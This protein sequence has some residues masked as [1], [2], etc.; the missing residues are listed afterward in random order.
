VN[1]CEYNN[2]VN[3]DT[4]L[5]R[6]S[7]VIW[8]F[9]IVLMCALVYGQVL[10]HDFIEYDDQIHFYNNPEFHP[11]TFA[12]LADFW[13]TQYEGL[14]IPVSYTF[15]A[16]IILVGRHLPNMTAIKQAADFNPLA[17]H[18]ASLII[19]TISSLIVFSLLRRWTCKDWP[20][21]VGALFFA[22]HPLQ[23]ESVCWASELRGLLA[24]AFGLG[25]V[26]VFCDR[27]KGG[28]KRDFWLRSAAAFAL[29][30]L[31]AL[32][33]P[34]MVP[35]PIVA[36]IFDRLINNTPWK[37]LAAEL[38][39]WLAVSAAV[40]I[41][42][43]SVQPVFE[44]NDTSLQDRPFIV[45]DTLFFYLEKL[46][47]PIKLSVDYGRNVFDVAHNPFTLIELCLLLALLGIGSWAGY[48]RRWPIACGIVSL[49]LILPVSGVVPY[50]FQ[51]F[52]TVGDRY[53]YAPILGAAMFI[54]RAL[55][56]K[57]LPQKIGVY[58]SGAIILMFAGLSA[59][60]AAL[61]LNARV[62]M[63]SATGLSSQC[64]QAYNVLGYLSQVDA[65]AA[66]ENEGKA[67]SL[68]QKSQ[69]DVIYKDNLLKS[70]DYENKSIALRPSFAMSHFALAM[71]YWKLGRAA[72]AISEHVLSVRLNPNDA[73][74]RLDFGSDLC[75]LGRYQE[76]YSQ[77]NAALK[78]NPNLPRIHYDL[79]SYYI[80]VADYESALAECQ[81]EIRNYP[82]YAPAYVNAAYALIQMNRPQGVLPLLQK[83]M[84]IGSIK[85]SWWMYMAVAHKMLGDKAASESD[86]D[87]ALAIDPS[88]PD[89]L[90]W[91][92]GELKK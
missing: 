4:L 72:D 27:D 52:S 20:S 78:I 40:S 80:D 17:L 36:V 58:A 41:A 35:L 29:F 25:A 24:A 81:L 21:A 33:K 73:E 6:H 44:M 38:S 87:N 49:A 88:Y 76:A 3:N 84:Q 11:I 28:L 92:R 86:V 91:K 2:V 62:L 30:V 83:A 26:L 43:R 60:Q 50:T 39:P 37:R 55:C 74:E 48:S 57:R 64:A 9:I 70:A 75:L 12:H 67:A 53:M 56:S 42:T 46:L 18:A 90:Q 22:L 65:D 7:S 15:F 61:W 10:G 5:N 32:S 89:A 54:A 82:N 71:D 34:T 16:A 19:H 31:A 85:P 51:Y 8:Q 66:F 47:L 77:L 69:Y 63:T 1:L 13:K 79:A 14:Y 23:V 68:V 45:A 59:T